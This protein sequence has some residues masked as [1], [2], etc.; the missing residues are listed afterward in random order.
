MGLEEASWIRKPGTSKKW[1]LTKDWIPLSQAAEEIEVH[2]STLRKYFYRDLGKALNLG[3]VG[4]NNRGWWYVH[5]QEVKKI[6]LYRFK[7]IRAHPPRHLVIETAS[8]AQPRRL[9][10]APIRPP[11]PPKK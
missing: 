7:E 5:P 6:K 11:K 10:T 3:K 8:A 2:P 4:K 1:K 9:P